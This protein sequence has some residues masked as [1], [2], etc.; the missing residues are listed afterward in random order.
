MAIDENFSDNMMDYE[1]EGGSS[2]TEEKKM[3]FES[4]RQNEGSVFS[5]QQ[6]VDPE[7]FVINEEKALLELKGE[8]SGIKETVS[9]YLLKSNSGQLFDGKLTLPEETGRDSAD[10][11]L[12]G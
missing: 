12:F 7:L 11:M 5:E 8:Q 2:T 4:Y 3:D 10:D 9:S 6:T 1:G